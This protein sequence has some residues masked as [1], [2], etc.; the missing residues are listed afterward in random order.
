MSIEGYS[1]FSI[2]HTGPLKQPVTR[3]YW[4]CETSSNRSYVDSALQR[5]FS[6][7]IIYLF[8]SF[9]NCYPAPTFALCGNQYSTTSAQ[10]IADF[11]YCWCNDHGPLSIYVPMW[12]STML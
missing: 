7:F 10:V 1:T 3:F 9:S 6:L 2:A 5:H 11:S 4:I 12:E 8:N